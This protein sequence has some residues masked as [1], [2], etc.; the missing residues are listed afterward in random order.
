M[1]SSKTF[2]FI[3]LLV[4]GFAGL[5]A[6]AHDVPQTLA[7]TIRL[8][9]AVVTGTRSATTARHLPATISVVD[10]AALTAHQRT[11]VLTTLTEQVPGLFT[12]GRAM[13]GYGVSGGAAGGINVRGLSSGTGQMLVLVDG[14]PQYQGIFGHSIA[15]AYQTMMAERVEV[16][17]G[18]ASVLY[19]SNAMGGVINIVTR[20]AKQD[21]V[22][23]GVH[24]GAGSWG[25]FQTEAYNQVRKGR[26]SSTV[27][28]QYGRSDNHRPN[29]GF[30]QYGGYV[31]LGYDI[32]DNWQAFADADV[33]HF[34]ASQPGSVTSP[35]L[36]CDQWI[37]RG[38]ATLAVENRYDKAS[39]RVSVYDN[40]GFHKID[41]GYAP[42]ATP[43]TEY[44]R[45]KDALVGASAY[46]TLSLFSGSHI[47]L[48]FDYQ[49]IFGHAY[50]TDRITGEVVTAGKRGMQ[51][52][53]QQLDEV[54]GYVDVRQDIARWLTL[55]AGVRYDYH[56]V[57]GGEWIPQAGL[58]VRPMAD[59]EVKATVGKG[60]RNP[61]VKDMYLYAVANDELLPER[62]WNYELSWRHRVADGRV[63]YGV[64]L[65]LLDGDNLIQTAPVDGKNRNVNIGKVLN[66]G[67]EADAT[68][69]VNSHWTLTTNHSYLH[70]KYHVLAAPQYKGYL[71]TTMRYGKW[72]ASAGLQQV[73]G[74]F[75]AVNAKD[76]SKETKENFTLLNATVAYQVLKQLQLWV[77]GDNL[78][79]QKYEINAGYPMPKATF[80]AGVN[81]NF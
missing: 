32:N 17:R 42:S 45:S 18:P 3:P 34:N 43:Q 76:A 47:T 11:N 26:F 54:A 22:H 63:N 40:F 41:D 15:D 80:M 59:G 20:Q 64:N 72:S 78:L 68:W 16:L 79:A 73:C 19:G 51:S 44:F 6:S 4:A 77:K 35:L 39:G 75:T 50:Y 65:F 49:H 56:T 5:T 67:V 38:V 24:L 2:R 31:R 27:A 61:T 30:E 52:T 81:V 7:D 33:T 46:E 62:A 60:F 53:D 71:G 23:T 74:L 70:M 66:K 25:T 9:D 36:D 12:T 58:V 37:T 29:M 13:M 21:G 48:G 55:N 57:A 10:R 1:T 28:A 69:H 14:H 8:D